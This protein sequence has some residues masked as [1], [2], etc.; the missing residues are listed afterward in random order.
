MNGPSREIVALDPVD[1]EVELKL[2]DG[3]GW[4]SQDKA[5]ITVSNCYDGTDRT[6]LFQSCRCT[7]ELSLQ[8]LATTVQATIVGVRVVEGGVAF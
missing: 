3:A 6:I 4:E 5:L 1:F 8:R 7:A 2:H